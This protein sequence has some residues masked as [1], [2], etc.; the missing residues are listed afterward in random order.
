VS[1]TPSNI[2]PAAAAR[3]L[4]E[5]G[6]QLWDG[7]FYALRPIEVLGLAA[8]GGVLRTGIVMYNTR[9]EVDRLVAGLSALAPGETEPNPAKPP[10]FRR[11]GRK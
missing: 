9:E 2:H 1:T 7:H 11:G 6:L 3:A 5:R 10:S 4:G 8:Q